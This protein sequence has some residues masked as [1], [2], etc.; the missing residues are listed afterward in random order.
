MSDKLQPWCPLC[1]H[2]TVIVAGTIDHGF[3]VACDKCGY[4][5]QKPGCTL[6]EN[7]QAHNEATDR[8]SQEKHD[9]VWGAWNEA[10]GRGWWLKGKA[11]EKL[12]WKWCEKVGMA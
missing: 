7:V 4:I 9:L 2:W 12:F 3:F 8:L 10:W 6:E 1:H 5:M 11:K